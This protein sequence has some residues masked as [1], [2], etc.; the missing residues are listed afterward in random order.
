MKINCC[1]S[2][3]AE[4]QYCFTR[5]TNQKATQYFA[6]GKHKFYLEYCCHR[7]CIKGTNKCSSCHKIHS[8][9]RSQFDS[10]Y[11]HGSIHEPIPDHS[12]IFGGTW[13]Q[14]RIALWGAPSAEV[15]ALAL[16]HQ[17]EAQ[18]YR[19]LDSLSKA[20]QPFISEEMAKPK[21]VLNEVP[22]EVPNETTVATSNP[23]VKRTRKPKIVKTVE[24]VEKVETVEIVEPIEVPVETVELVDQKPKRKPSKSTKKVKET[25]ISLN[26]PP[27]CKEV[28]IPTHIEHTI[29]TVDIDGYDIEYVPLT[30]VEINH[31]TYFRDAKKNK[32][33]Q[34]IKDKIIGS[35]VGRYCPHTETICTEV[36]DS[37]EENDS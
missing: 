16:Q 5:I 17:Q 30:Y 29:E 23:P 31:T 1:T 12:H 20:N 34:K 2:E 28:V 15:I 11:P 27:I 9:A 32:L 7:P 13:Y 22:N 37:D 8:G 35:Y 6:D 33:Y 25:T 36:P 21:K 26:D 10:T 24:T 19:T 14:E 3:M 18:R 4:V